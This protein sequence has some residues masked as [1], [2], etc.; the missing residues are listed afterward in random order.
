[1]NPE[2]QAKLEKLRNDYAEVRGQPFNHFFCPIL[3]RDEDTEPCKGHIINEVFPN[4][5]RRWTVQRKDVDGFFGAYFE[6]DFSDLQYANLSP[7]DILLDDKLRKR[8]DPRILLN[9]TEVEYFPMRDSQIPQDFTP[10]QVNNTPFVLKKPLSEVSAEQQHKWEVDPSKDIRLAALVSL[11][12][13]A[14]LTLFDLLGYRYVCSAGGY[15]VGRQILGEFFLN[16]NGKSKAE[17]LENAHSF[18]P[19]FANMLRPVKPSNHGLEGTLT[20]K[21]V[22]LCLTGNDTVWAMIVFVKTAHMLHSILLPVIEYAD[23]ASHFLS[24]LNNSNEYIEVSGCKFDGTG[25]IVDAFKTTLYWPKT[26][27]FYP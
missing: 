27:V 19:E 25:F 23:I 8:F 12:K 16:N 13:A 6:S 21:K 15:F 14:H 9:G 26:G 24:F 11:L 10:I 3:F 1:M 4:S 22:F 17:I 20:D 18:F 2:L 5:A 7:I